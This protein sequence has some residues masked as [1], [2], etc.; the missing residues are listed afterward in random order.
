MKYR[1]TMTPEQAREVSRA[2]ELYMRLKL[3][4]Y[5]ELPFALMDLSDKDFAEKR[6]EAK[7][8]LKPGFDAM[9]KGRPFDKAKDAQWHTLYNLHQVVRHAIWQAE[10]PGTGG[11]WSYEP[12]DMGDVGLAKIEIVR[13][14]KE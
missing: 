4:Q 1:L 11:V 8:Y 7:K 9:L 2:C 3:G 5:E 14:G 6:D 13:E 10:F 12:M